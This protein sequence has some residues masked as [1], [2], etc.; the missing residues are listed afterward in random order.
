MSQLMCEAKEKALPHELNSTGF[1]VRPL[2]SRDAIFVDQQWCIRAPRVS[3]R[4]SEKKR[5]GNIS[6]VCDVSS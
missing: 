4:K 1:Q 5:V 3:R 2:K 6:P